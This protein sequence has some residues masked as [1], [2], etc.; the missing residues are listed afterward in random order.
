MSDQD[1]QARSAQA[2]SGPVISI[3]DD[4][5]TAVVESYAAPADAP[6]LS[7]D[8][9][10]EAM[11][12]A[13]VMEPEGPLADKVLLK[14]KLRKDIT[15]MTVAEGRNPAKARDARLE[16]K[17][18]MA[19]PVF[20]NDVFAVLHPSEPPRP[21]ATVRGAPIPAPSDKK[22]AEIAIAEDSGALLDE[23][24]GEVRAEVY[25]LVDYRQGKLTVKPLFRVAANR[26]EITA[27][28]YPRSFRNAPVSVD[29]IKRDLW[30]M[31]ARTLAERAVDKALEKAA[32]SG[33]A[34]EGVVVARGAAPV[35]GEDGRFELAFMGTQ[36]ALAGDESHV[37]DPRERSKFEPIAEGTLIGQLIPPKEGRFG[38]DVFGE[39]LVPRKGRPAEVHAGENVEVSENGVEFTSA[40]SGMITWDRNRVS[41]LEMVHVTGDISFSTGNLRLENGSVLIDGSIRDGFRVAAPGDV[42]VGLAIESAEVAAGGNVGVKGGIVMGGEGKVRAKG[43]VSCNFAENAVIE[44]EGDVIVAHNLSTSMVTARR[45]VIC[46]KGKGIVLGGVVEAGKGVE[47]NEIGSEF[48]VKTMVRLDMGEEIGG[49]DELV[50]ERKALRAQKSQIDGAIGTEDPRKLLART[51]VAKR[52]QVAEII[53]KRISIINRMKEIETALEGRRKALEEVSHIRV[54]VRR[55]AH[56]G[57]VISIADKKLSLHEP[58]DGP[59]QFYY[60]PETTAIVME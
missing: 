44:A 14:A 29:M 26:L 17:G 27:T 9:L 41:V 1:R 2:G 5:M 37:V 39:D 31:G 46:V 53:K 20:H 38:R 56:P 47:A 15:G 10:Y 35:H 21:G 12:A 25:G 22:P 30:A 49:V 13:G 40:I 18:D 8:I 55:V 57:T 60:D 32:A 24:S 45:R 43:D 3:S 42:C 11:R 28:L 54:K 36:E 34:Q 59:C 16:F 4:G 7:A 50:A 52:A 33:E 23:E 6:P 58:V 19:W 48:G 51:P